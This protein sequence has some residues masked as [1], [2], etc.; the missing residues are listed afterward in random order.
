MN[1]K[2]PMKILVFA[3][4]LLTFTNCQL[5]TCS[6][7]TTDLSNKCGNI[8][9]SVDSEC[10]AQ[11]CDD[12]GPNYDGTDILQ[13]EFCVNNATQPTYIRCEGLPCVLDE[14]CNLD[15]CYNN[16]CDFKGFINQPVLPAANSIVLPLVVAVPIGAIVGF[17][18]GCWIGGMRRKKL[19]SDLNG[20]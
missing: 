9:C 4:F 1:A 7:S 15:T 19:K 16:V 2:M 18:I 11:S 13:C 17:A 20:Y 6:S 10:Q 3:S 5:P 14:E 8:T 12:N